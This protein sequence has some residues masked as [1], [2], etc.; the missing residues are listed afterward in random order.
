MYF[1]GVVPFDQIDRITVISRKRK[2]QTNLIGAAI[3]GAA[4]Y[5]VGRQLR[6]DGLRQAN[7]E[8][9]SQPPQNGFI[10]PILG[11]IIGAGLGTV[12]GDLFTPV[13]IENV[14]KNPREAAKKLRSYLPAKRKK[15]SRRR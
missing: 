10:E 2:L 11:G 12:I 13:Q 3:G 1:N 14:N 7:I 5:L 9:I 6:P 8:L 15:K 4:G